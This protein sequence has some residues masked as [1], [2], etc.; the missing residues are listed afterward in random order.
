MK[1]SN[2][3]PHKLHH[4]AVEIIALNAIALGLVVGTANAFAGDDD[5]A[6]WKTP[7]SAEFSKLDTSGN[8]LL[9][10]NEAIKGH[11]FDKKSFAKAD[12]DH[13][14][15]IDEKE[16]IYYK[17]GA[18][19]KEVPLIQDVAAPAPSMPS[20]TNSNSTSV[21]EPIA[22]PGPAELDATPPKAVTPD[23][24]TPPPT[25]DPANADKY[26]RGSIDE[27]QAPSVAELDSYASEK[28][29]LIPAAKSAS[30]AAAS[31][32][33]DGRAIDDNVI[34][35]K[36]I[37]TILDTDELEGLE[38]SV[39]THQGEVLLDGFVRSE[40]DRMKTEYVVSMIDGVKSVR[41]YLKVKSEANG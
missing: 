16:Y 28:V 29:E 3:F 1:K 34:N 23:P 14:G 11:A 12:V 30:V 15:S 40:K 39:E 38:I 35:T 18:W 6:D 2:K 20:S 13:D 10:L 25:P 7:L 24:N 22:A 36:A 4:I 19:P 41:N 32:E 5:G 33:T 27:L 8:G 31:S 17:T 9:M 26:N 21:P 37:A